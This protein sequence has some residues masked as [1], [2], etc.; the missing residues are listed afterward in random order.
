MERILIKLS[1]EGLT[2]SD[3][4]LL[5]DYSKVK[6][7]AYE[8][9]KL[10]SKKIQVA[11]VVG[12]GNFWRGA[13]ATKNGIERKKA[14][15]IGMMATVMNALALQGAFEDYG[16]KTKVQSSI[17]IDSRI[18]EP[19]IYETAEK[20]LNNGN[21][22]IFAGG[23]GRP[24]F[25]T[26]TCAI[27]VAAE[28]KAQKVLMGKNGVDGVYDSDPKLNKN[29]QRFNKLTFSQILDKDLKVMDSTAV[30]MARENNINILVFDINA[31]NAISRIIDNNI[32]HTIITNKV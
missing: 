19:L 1:G 25:T 30:A 3:K 32:K 18:I 23:T 29:A 6:I 5:I 11:I 21:V 7:L 15:Y 4:N 14:D 8:I 31:K 9:K 16:V 12:G 27:L 24:F 26:D 13:S 20:Y 28:I 10:L 2:S 22:V 17:Q